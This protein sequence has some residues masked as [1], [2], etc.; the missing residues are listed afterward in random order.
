MAEFKERPKKGLSDVIDN[1]KAFVRLIRT[2]Y[3]GM[4]PDEQAHLDR[5]DGLSTRCAA[6]VRL[7]MDL[8]R[9]FSYNTLDSFYEALRLLLDAVSDTIGDFFT[10][11]RIPGIIRS[12]TMIENTLEWIKYMLSDVGVY[13]LE[14]I[15]MT[16]HPNPF[17]PIP[18]HSE[19]WY[20]KMRTEHP[21]PLVRDR[22]E[23]I[24]SNL[25][26]LQEPTTVYTARSMPQ[27][28]R[29]Y[30]SAASMTRLSAPTPR[31]SRSQFGKRKSRSRT[32][33]GSRKS[34]PRSKKRGITVRTSSGSQFR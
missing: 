4:N 29:P 34:G 3:N 14:E 8:E 31:L 16:T 25:L 18:E 11:G 5:K 28:S 20:Y 32:T 26:K 17:H 6:V 30:I 1:T 9:E 22:Y 23:R 10:T 27:N 15:P 24:F 12:R 7:R 19:E 2:D 21:D 13:K 33:R